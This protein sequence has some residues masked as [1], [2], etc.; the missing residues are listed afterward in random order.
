[1]YVFHAVLFACLFT[2]VL[3]GGWIKGDGGYLCIRNKQFYFFDFRECEKLLIDVHKLE[4]N[5]IFNVLHD[6]TCQYLCIST[7]GNTYISKNYNEDCL[8]TTSAF[9]YAQ[10][11]SV[12]RGNFSN[13]LTTLGSNRL[14]PFSLH[15]GAR[16]EM[17]YYALS[18]EYVSKSNDTACPFTA[19]LST[20]T[21]N[22]NCRYP[23]FEEKFHTRRYYHDYTFWERLLLFLGIT[24]EIYPLPYSWLSNFE[25]N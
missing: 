12:N 14:L 1:M 5:L 17:M 23:Y 6:G 3:A 20:P 24:H 16:M 7:C 4:H 2:S 18:M 21:M 19:P 8:W 9:D 25:Y 13:F 11:L 22:T 10:T 15:D